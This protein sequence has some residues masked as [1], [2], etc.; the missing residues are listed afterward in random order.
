VSAEGVLD[1]LQDGGRAEASAWG[2]T[3]DPFAPP[4]PCGHRTL[5]VDYV[6]ALIQDDLGLIVSREV[7]VRVRCA[8]CGVPCAVSLEVRRP[9]TGEEHGLVLSVTPLEE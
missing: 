4:K 7:R 6:T 5:G 2:K 9:K 8:E 1:A 3:I